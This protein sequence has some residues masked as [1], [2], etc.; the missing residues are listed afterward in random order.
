MVLKK[1]R[2]NSSRI[3]LKKC[4]Q[5][6]VRNHLSRI[7]VVSGSNVKQQQQGQSSSLW[8][9]LLTCFKFSEMQKLYAQRIGTDL[10]TFVLIDL[11]KRYDPTHSSEP[12][13]VH[14]LKNNKIV[15][16]ERDSGS[17]STG[18][19]WI[20]FSHSS[21]FILLFTFVLFELGSCN[22][23]HG[24]SVY[25]RVWSPIEVYSREQ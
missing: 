24:I 18:K 23:G 8:V 9:A 16:S 12:N 2:K 14:V 10:S 15:S 22:C 4:W 5:Q 3:G 11:L 1:R 19:T 25:Y 21:Q 17:A 20:V 13:K 7:V 6:S